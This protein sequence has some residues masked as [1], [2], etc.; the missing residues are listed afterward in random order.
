[1]ATDK[2]ELIDWLSN[3][4]DDAEIG[5]E[6]GGLGQLALIAQIPGDVSLE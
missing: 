6:I 5:I 4:S 2:A 1:M 3:V